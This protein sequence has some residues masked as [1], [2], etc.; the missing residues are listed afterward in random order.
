MVLLW[1]VVELEFEFIFFIYFCIH[2]ESML[3]SI[4]SKEYSGRWKIILGKAKELFMLCAVPRHGRRHWNKYLQAE[5]SAITIN[6][7]TGSI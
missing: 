5:F 2:H 4:I 3:W 6:I 1:L 7:S